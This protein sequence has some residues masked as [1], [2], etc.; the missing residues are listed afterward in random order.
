MFK[1]VRKRDY[2]KEVFDLNKITEAVYNAMQSSGNGTKEDATNISLEVFDVLS[3]RNGR[4]VNYIPSI[5]EIQDVVEQRLMQSQFLDVA[6]CYILYRN[7]QAQKR[8]PNI[9]EKRI[10]LKPYEYPDLY[11]YVAAIRHSYWIH[12]EFNFTSDIQDFKTKLTD[13]ERSAIKNTM[14]AISQIEVAVKSFWGDIYQ[15]IPKPEVGSVGA[16]FGEK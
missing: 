3:E 11:E 15:K 16:T 13:K 14:L 12:S 4:I 8:K 2:T 6:K 10:N 5:E 7:E 1:E 9:F